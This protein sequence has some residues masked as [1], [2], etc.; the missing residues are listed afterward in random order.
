MRWQN[1]VC[2]AIARFYKNIMCF[3]KTSVSRVITRLGENDKL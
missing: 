1:T 2:V 3:L